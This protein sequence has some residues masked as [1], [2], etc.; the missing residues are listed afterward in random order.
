LGLVND[1][2]ENQS[3]N[4][5]RRSFM[6]RKVNIL[7]TAQAGCGKTTV[8]DIIAVALEAAGF[9]VVFDELELLDREGSRLSLNERVGSLKKTTSVFIETRLARRNEKL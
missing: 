5:L 6:D 1:I 3:V 2:P 9:E 8:A 4:Y 7:I